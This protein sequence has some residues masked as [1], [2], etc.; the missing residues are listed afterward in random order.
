MDEAHV[1]VHV[2]GDVDAAS[3]E[4]FSQLLELAAQQRDEVA[5]HLDEVTFLDSAALRVIVRATCAVRDAGGSL[6]LAGSSA[7]AQQILR[8]SGLYDVLRSGAQGDLDQEDAS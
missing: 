1:A 3:A 6:W 8:T 5:L 7:I 2:A 4:Q